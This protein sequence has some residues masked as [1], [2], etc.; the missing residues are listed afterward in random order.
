MGRL[1]QPVA[2]GASH[3]SAAAE[4]F[5]SP[6]VPYHGRQNCQ[7]KGDQSGSRFSRNE[8]RPSTASS[9]P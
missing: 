7:G 1:A 6:A 3:P 4:P 2:H 8:S 5:R 9:V